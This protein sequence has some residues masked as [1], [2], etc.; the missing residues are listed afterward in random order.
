[1]AQMAP[2]ATE[3]REFRCARHSPAR[4]AT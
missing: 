3:H 1:V 4:N 2:R